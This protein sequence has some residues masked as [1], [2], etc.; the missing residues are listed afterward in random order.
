MVHDASPTP[1]PF[2]P[3]HL[4]T[5]DSIATIYP[6]GAH[7]C[8]WI[9]TGQPDAIWLSS[10]AVFA[11]MRFIRGGVPICF[12]WFGA[13]RTGTMKPP[14]GFARL[15]P[16]RVQKQSANEVEFTLSSCDLEAA[17]KAPDI[18]AFREAFPHQF[19]ASYQ[20]SIGETLTL[21]LTVHN[22]GDSAFDYQEALHTFL[23]V[24]DVR[25]IRIE[26][27]DGTTYLDNSPN[28]LSEHTQ[29]GD[30]IFS[31]GI[32]RIYFSRQ[33]IQVVDEGFSRTITVEREDADL[34]VI[35][36]PWEKGAATMPDMGENE[37][38]TMI[39]VEGAN[40]FDSSIHL[41][42][43]ESHSMLYRLSITEHASGAQ[44]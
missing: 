19:T 42:A 7:L 21:R 2:T 25:T 44:S 3:I 36:N 18:H 4:R 31:T 39:C 22:D 6:H 23:A 11:D 29:R 41:E 33:P 34:A 28:G 26:G 38:Q 20:V 13:G 24:S 1:D 12:P 15:L 10:G 14:H 16:W 35:W 37:W 32:D 27:L 43:G 8:S 9:P 30:L 5:A 17:K 40:A